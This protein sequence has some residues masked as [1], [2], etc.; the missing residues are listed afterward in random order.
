MKCGDE[1]TVPLT[2]ALH[3]ELDGRA[4]LPNGEYGNR[5]ME[6]G[7]YRFEHFYQVDLI[8]EAIQRHLDWME[9]QKRGNGNRDSGTAA[10]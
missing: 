7:R 5:R 4:K 6:D 1:W 2:P 3:D 9:E 10:A 8:E